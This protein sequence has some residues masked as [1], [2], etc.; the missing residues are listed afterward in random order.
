MQPWQVHTS[1]SRVLSLRRIAGHHSDKVTASIAPTQT[2]RPNALG[3]RCCH[4]IKSI[5]MSHGQLLA[6]LACRTR[7]REKMMLHFCCISSILI[8]PPPQSRYAA[9]VQQN[10]VQRPSF[11]RW[12]ESSTDSETHQTKWRKTFTTHIHACTSRRS[13]CRA[14]L[15]RIANLAM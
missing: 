8:S 12:S 9:P 4:P 13:S 14:S 1:H 10:G 15:G 2:V 6:I 11:K 5:T 7:A 3:Q